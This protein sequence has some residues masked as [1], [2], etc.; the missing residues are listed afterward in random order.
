MELLIYTATSV[1]WVHCPLYQATNRY[2]KVEQLSTKIGWSHWMRRNTN[3][4]VLKQRFPAQFKRWACIRQCRHSIMPIFK[5]LFAVFATCKWH[6]LSK[7]HIQYSWT[8]PMERCPKKE[9]V[10]KCYINYVLFSSGAQCR[11][12]WRLAP[13]LWT[14]T[15]PLLDLQVHPSGPS[16]A[17]TIGGP[18]AGA[19]GN[20]FPFIQMIN[21]GSPNRGGCK[22]Y[23]GDTVQEVSDFL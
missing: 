3:I 5:T 23:D 18:I 19:T 16:D 14:C 8:M 17:E 9:W 6:A 22:V 1:L 4:G 10:P 20:N 15:S 12:T 13:S 7:Q 21:H 11:A 2:L